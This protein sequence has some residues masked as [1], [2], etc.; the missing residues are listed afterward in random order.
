[1]FW[2]KSSRLPGAHV[3]RTRDEVAVGAVV[4]VAGVLAPSP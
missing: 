4:T 3:E 1:M 2:L